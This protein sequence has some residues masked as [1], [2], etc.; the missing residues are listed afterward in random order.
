MFSTNHLDQSHHAH[1]DIGIDNGM[2]ACAYL[3]LVAFHC[4]APSHLRSS[5]PNILDHTASLTRHTFHP[6]T[7]LD[8]AF[9]RHRPT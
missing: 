6:A 3:D 7:C 5:L 9:L 8:L 4:I 1:A 2:H